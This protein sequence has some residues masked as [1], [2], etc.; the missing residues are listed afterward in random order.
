V[1]FEDG[2]KQ[3]QQGKAILI[4]GN[5]TEIHEWSRDRQEIQTFDCFYS[6]ANQTNK[7]PSKTQWN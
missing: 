5:K 6:H 4:P 2:A 7:I 1:E 3:R